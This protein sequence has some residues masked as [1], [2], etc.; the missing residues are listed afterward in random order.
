MY[1]VSVVVRGP[2]ELD[3]KKQI[4]DANVW[5][6][7]MNLR[8]MPRFLSHLYLLSMPRAYGKTANT[9][10]LFFTL[11]KAIICNHYRYSYALSS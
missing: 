6:P 8:P 11:Q 9:M 10:S 1:S 3:T 5:T 7:K 4:S 2:Q